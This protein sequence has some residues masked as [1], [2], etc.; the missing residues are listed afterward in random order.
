M[1]IDTAIRVR[2]FY[3]FPLK[4]LN[5]AKSAGADDAILVQRRRQAYVPQ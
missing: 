4:R 1:G 5:G 3:D 2:H